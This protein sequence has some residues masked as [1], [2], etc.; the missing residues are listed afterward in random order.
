MKTIILNNEY[1]CPDTCAVAL[2]FFDGVHIGH[3]KILD[4]ALARKDDRVKSAILT[5]LDREDFKPT[6]KR[7]TTEEE[8][9][10]I[11]SRLGFDY[12]FL[13]DFNEIR[14]MTCRDFCKK[15]LVGSCNAIV[16]VCG[17]NFKFGKGACGSSDDL[18]RYMNGRAV[19]CEELKANGNTVSSTSIRAL[20]QDGL[21]DKANALLFSPFS[22]TAE[23][24]HG[25]E[26]GRK[27]GVPTVNQQFPDSLTVPKFGVYVSR[28][29]IDDESFPSV[30]NVGM[31]PTVNDK[32]M[33]AETHI[34]GFDKQ[35]YGKTVTVEFL[36]Y[37][38]PEIKFASIDELRRQ[39]K[40]DIEEA[41]AYGKNLD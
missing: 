12:L 17:R 37:I 1:R 27:I 36:K 13:C 41:A 9:F 22:V 25:K 7:I 15:I 2:G 14:D 28:T 6:N 8:R 21:I 40:A 19:V 16:A 32:L 35:L 10:R 34:I 31:H 11:F 4:E 5:F 24:V 30:T 3:R 26:L 29:F 39:I 18:I 23:V 38:R 33:N 20:I